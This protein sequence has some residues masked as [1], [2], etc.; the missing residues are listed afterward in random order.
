MKK[1]YTAPRLYAEPFQLREHISDCGATG[2]PTHT[3]GK[4]TFEL[5]GGL[6]IFADS[7]I[8]CMM[9]PEMLE[10]YDADLYHGTIS[11]GFF[12]S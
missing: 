3:E 11:A 9:T 12:G 10:D 6:A 4:C 5:L 2:K 1:A 7:L 8:G